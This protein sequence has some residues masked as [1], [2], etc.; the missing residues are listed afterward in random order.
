MGDE[1]KETLNMSQLQ[2]R[3]NPIYEGQ[4]I[5]VEIPEGAA[6]ELTVTGVNSPRESFRVPIRS[7]GAVGLAQFSLYQAGTYELKAGILATTISIQPQKDLSFLAEFGLLA[8]SVI[9]V[10]GGL[11]WWKRRK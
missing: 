6:T 5:S 11:I 3:P 9:I 4:P 10:W 7:Q 1:T 8:S 2:V